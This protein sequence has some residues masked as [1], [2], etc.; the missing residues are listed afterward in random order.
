MAKYVYGPKEDWSWKEKVDWAKFG[1]AKKGC[2]GRM[3][4]LKSKE[5]AKDS[6]EFQAL[7]RSCAEEF[8]GL[9]VPKEM[10]F[11]WAQEMA[12]YVYGPKEDWS[13]KEK[14][15]LG[16]GDGEVRVRTEGGL[17]LE[18]EGG[19]GEVWR[20]EEGVH[21]P[22]GGA[23]EQGGGQGLGGVPGADPQLRRG[24]RWPGRAEGDGVRLGAGDGQVRQR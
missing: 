17:E 1:A 15:R 20:R 12:K 18:G 23:Q 9:D 6:E 5:V 4:A 14:V 13:W 16:A 24:V 21:G 8:A 7:I 19:L 2:M 22:H 10:A 11:D 3:E